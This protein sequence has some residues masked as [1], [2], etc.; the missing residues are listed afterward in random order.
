MIDVD[1]SAAEEDVGRDPSARA[2]LIAFV[3]VLVVALPV[4]LY[5][6]RERWFR[7]DEWDFL[8]SR[9]ATSLHDLFE[10]HAVHLTALPILVFRGLWKVFGLESYRPYQFVSVVS[11]LAVAA[12]VRTVMRRAG[13]RP[14]TATAVATLLVFLGSGEENILWAF[15]I[16]FTAALAFG[17]AQLILSD[18]DGPIDR[19]DWLG[20]LAGFAGLL[21]SGVA[22]TMV[23]VVG[24]AVLA[25]R[26]WRAAAFHTV[27]LGVAFGVWYLAIGHEGFEE[28]ASGGDVVGFSRTAIAQ[29]F[30]GM[31][32]V[33]FLGWA[34]G[35]LVVG[36]CYLAWRGLPVEEL[37]RR[38]AP[39]AALLI[40]AFVFIVISGSGRGVDV[41]DATRFTHIFATL[42]LPA[43]AVAADA[44]MVRWRVTAPIF[45][46]VLAA[47][48]VGNVRLFDND[49][50]RLAGRFQKAYRQNFLLTPRLP[51][52]DAVPRGLHPDLAL[53]PWVTLGWMRD[54]VADG[55][56]PAPAKVSP[57]VRATSELQLALRQ[58]YRHEPTTCAP[59][60]SPSVR[61]AAGGSLRL[62]TPV[63]VVFTD[64][65]GVRSAPVTFDPRAGVYL[66]AYAG[67][68]R[69]DVQTTPPGGRVEVCDPAGGPF[70]V[71]PGP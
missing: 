46:V 11:H 43:I 39:P 10:A 22:V 45:A 9:S 65:S 14:W 34:L 26:G 7:Y 36:G 60:S 16:T 58:E 20:L 15:Q 30:D 17:L 3:V 37:R 51:L 4:L 49:A 19:R 12:L 6:G 41:A 2:A 62:S 18:H 57:T 24:L 23:I 1:V 68:L 31:A 28:T 21:C 52:A 61:L 71:Q 35:A 59:L 64:D 25:R 54:G 33:P 66:L 42:S 47:A 44:V 48:I 50:Q 55:R 38:A 63:A 32:Q 70:V 67:P 56:F 29:A 8:A 5:L 40:G 27:P 69:L 13:V 53:A